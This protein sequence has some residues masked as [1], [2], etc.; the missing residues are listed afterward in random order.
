MFQRLIYLIPSK[1]KAMESEVPKWIKMLSIKTPP[2]READSGQT[3]HPPTLRIYD[4]TLFSPTQWTLFMEPQKGHK[5]SSWS[6]ES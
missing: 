5:P 3:S 1:N 4:L 2:K 6:T